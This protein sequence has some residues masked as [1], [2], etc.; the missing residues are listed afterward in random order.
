MKVNLLLAVALA[1]LFIWNPYPFQ[2]LELKSLDALIMSRDEVQDEM[3]LLVDIDEDTVEKFGGYPLSRDVYANLL[4]I[5]QG[6]PGITVAFP[7]KD[8]HGKDKI[9][10]TTLNHIPT[11]LSFIGSTQAFEG[12]PH[13]GTAQIGGGNPAEWLYQY[14]GILRSALESQGVGLISTMPEL[15]GVVRRLPLAIS[16][17]NRIYPSFALE[18]L[19]LGTGDPSYQIKTEE[20][21][22]EWIRLPQYNKITT[23]ENG[24]VWANWN[25]K[26]YR[27]TALEYL[28]EPIPA[29]FVIFGVTA[30]GVAPLVATPGGVKY[31]HDIQATVLNT[32]VNGNALS[33]PSWSFL[34][35]LG[36]ILIGMVLIM[37]VASNIY[38]SLPVI[39]ALLGGLGYTSWKLVESSYLFD[40]SGTLVILFLFWSIV[41]F[42]SFITQYLL[43]LQIKQQFGTY[44]SPAL[45]EKLQKDPTLLRLGGV[46][47]RLTFLFSDIRGFT[48]ISEKYQSDPQKLVE[49]VNRF[50]TNQTEI[51]Q[52]HEGCVDKYMGDC[53]MAFWNAPLDVEDQERKAIECALEMREAL[54][55]LNE[56][57]KAE[58]IPEIHTGCGINTGLCVVGNMGSTTR[59]DYSVLG[60]AV[61]LAARLESS[62]KTYETDLI[63]S[64]HSLVDGY[65][66]KFLDE[67]VVKGK[68]EPV[69]I[70]T[71]QK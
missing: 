23:S 19:R 6:V 56:V 10:Q 50:L 18:M 21:G 55:E 3:I 64:E 5:T 14:P 25:T 35:E 51:I 40:V 67:V 30:E 16:V 15:D 54:G 63:I 33:Q 29:P 36:I 53:I 12:G 59:F 43:R 2:I 46:T 57:F 70:Y 60:D 22:V 1:A 61:N 69:K 42:R 38:L 39:L 71:I 49:I 48:P 28:K 41:Q 68:S 13:V 65:E 52:K 47:K 58:K 17:E 8:L 34:A 31:P 4:T 9:F 45:V 20:T 66:Y 24:T 27:Q 32:I 7:D 26:F 44:V 62:C 37:M 11:V